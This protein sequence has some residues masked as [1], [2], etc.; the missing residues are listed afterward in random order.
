M[1]AGRCSLPSANWSYCASLLCQD[2]RLEMYT[3]K[4][5][6]CE[7]PRGYPPNPRWGGGGVWIYHPSL[8]IPYKIFKIPL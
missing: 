4:R 3:L 7:E 2:M 5:F 8:Y 1:Y 6:F